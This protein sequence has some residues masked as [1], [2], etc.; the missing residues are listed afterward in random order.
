MKHWTLIFIFFVFCNLVFAQEKTLTQDELMQF[1]ESAIA[2][3]TD[4]M[5]ML[6]KVADNRATKKNRNYYAEQVLTLFIDDGL[7]T[8]IE[9]AWIDNNNQTNKISKLIPAYLNDLMLSDKKFKRKE[10]SFAQTFYVSNFYPSGKNKYVATA[11][12]FQVFRGYNSE[13]EAVFENITGRTIQI[14][15]ELFETPSGDIWV[16]KL[17]DISVVDV[18]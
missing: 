6:P 9:I 7:K 3:M 12:I 4:F 1:H 5:D 16:L 11:K 10:I 13:G 15:I 17:G 18:L 2:K 8:N 14:V